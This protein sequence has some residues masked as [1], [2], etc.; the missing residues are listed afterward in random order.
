MSDG[1]FFVA[2]FFLVTGAAMLA[3]MGLRACHR[4]NMRRRQWWR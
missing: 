4:W 1:Q 3:E 2:L